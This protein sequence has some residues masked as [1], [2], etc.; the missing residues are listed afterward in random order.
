MPK[1]TCALPELAWSSYFSYRKRAGTRRWRS[2]RVFTPTICLSIV[3]LAMKP[4]TFSGSES[5]CS[6]SIV[7]VWFPLESVSVQTWAWMSLPF[8]GS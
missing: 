1:D 6:K 8:L 3:L 2:G 4:E 7:A 5:I